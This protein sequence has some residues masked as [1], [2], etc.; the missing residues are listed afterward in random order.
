[1]KHPNAKA[2]RQAI[3]NEMIAEVKRN[4][5]KELLIES[6]PFAFFLVPALA[7]II[8]MVTA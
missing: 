6:L 7:L 5:A 1:M 3:L 8:G 2:L 4:K